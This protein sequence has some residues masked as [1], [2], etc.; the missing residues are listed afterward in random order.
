MVNMEKSKRFGWAQFTERCRRAVYV[1]TEKARSYGDAAVEPEHLLAGLLDDNE[2]VAH[3]I[4]N[5]LGANLV[6]MRD[7]MARP[8]T[9]RLTFRSEEMALSSS[10]RRVIE[11][12]YACARRLD[13]N[14]I[15][16][17]HLL[18]G[19]IQIASGDSALGGMLSRNSIN[20]D[21]VWSVIGKMRRSSGRPAG[22]GS[23]GQGGRLKFPAFPIVRRSRRSR[24]RER[25]VE[26]RRDLTDWLRTCQGIVESWFAGAAPAGRPC[27]L[28]WGCFSGYVR[29][30]LAHADK[31][32]LNP[33]ASDAW[34]RMAIA[35]EATHHALRKWPGLARSLW[36][37]EMLCCRAS[38][39]I[40]R[41]RREDAYVDHILEMYRSKVPKLP[42][43]DAKVVP[44]WRALFST[45]ARRMPDG[46][47]AVLTLRGLELAELVGWPAMIS[48]AFVGSWDEWLGS[49]PPD[50][51]HGAAEILELP[52]RGPG[53][54]DRTIPG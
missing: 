51:E 13:D 7:D 31:I 32:V 11:R 22:A 43:A 2:N 24:E 53:R 33:Y 46:Y 25:P 49:L 40:M 28:A 23:R 9:N 21:A 16:T 54:P 29:R 47:H 27:T 6:Q 18:L 36:V 17:E 48:L 38:V 41:Q 3:W 15:G 4:L 8:L 19:I 30:Y 14:H 52:P 26:G 5:R 45:G 20:E 12:A 1:A 39:E 35:H 50:I 42:L 44:S 34:L 37:Q 10:G